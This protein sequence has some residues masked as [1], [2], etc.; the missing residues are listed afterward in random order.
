MQT[1]NNDYPTQQ[2]NITIYAIVSL[3]VVFIATDVATRRVRECFKIMRI[4]QLDHWH[5]CENCFSFLS[6]LSNIEKH[7][8]SIEC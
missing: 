5:I 4:S 7:A 6:D 2:T 1:G 3:K 8:I